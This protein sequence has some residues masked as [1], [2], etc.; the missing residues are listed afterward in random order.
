M[1]FSFKPHLRHH[2]EIKGNDFIEVYIIK[3]KKT[4]LLFLSA[5]TVQLKWFCVYKFSE[6]FLYISVVTTDFLFYEQI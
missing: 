5:K 2:H 4:S 6:C 1:K 3:K